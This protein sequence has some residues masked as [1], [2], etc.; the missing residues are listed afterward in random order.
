MEMIFLGV[1][2]Q[3]G[4]LTL[5]MHS[6]WEYAI[7]REVVKRQYFSNLYKRI[8]IRDQPVGLTFAGLNNKKCLFLL[9]I[10]SK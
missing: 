10:R 2:V 7:R 8:C 1:T 6:C 4:E 3:L 5:L 9:E